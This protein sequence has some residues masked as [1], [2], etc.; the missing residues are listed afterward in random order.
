MMCEQNGQRDQTPSLHKDTQT[1][2]TTPGGMAMELILT[3]PT[4]MDFAVFTTRL[5]IC[6]RALMAQ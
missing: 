4:V 5:N 1:F 6:P 2:A 3:M